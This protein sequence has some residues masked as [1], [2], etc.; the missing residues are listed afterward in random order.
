LCKRPLKDFDAA[1]AS[2]PDF[3]KVLSQFGI[4]ADKLVLWGSGKPLREFLWSEDMADA[5]VHVLLNV[6]FNDLKGSNPEVRNTHINVGTGL[7][8]TIGE[9]AQA[10]RAEVGF[11]GEIC[12][13][14]SKPDGTMRKLCNVDKLHSLG[15]HHHVELP[16]GIARLYKWYLDN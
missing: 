6:T 12:W 10:I 15:W 3:A 16:D 9:L 7:E 13:D 8:L 11:T 2:L 14:A 1:N 5:S 4:Y